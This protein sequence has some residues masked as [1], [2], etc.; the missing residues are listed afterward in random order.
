MSET[1][2]GPMHLL[3]IKG[4]YIHPDCFEIR[5]VNGSRLYV[6]DLHAFKTIDGTLCTP[7]SLRK[8]ESIWVDV[9]AF[10]ADGSLLEN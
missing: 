7:S 9:H 2:I 1:K 5:F 3:E 8:G 10:R 4:I 6:I